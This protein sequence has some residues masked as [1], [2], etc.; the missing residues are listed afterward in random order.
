M[1]I[2]REVITVT[3]GTAEQERNNDGIRRPDT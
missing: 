3:S 2:D 1:M